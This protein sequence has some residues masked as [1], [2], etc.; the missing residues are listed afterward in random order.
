MNCEVSGTADGGM[1]LLARA[2]LNKQQQLGL[3]KCGL[4]P[5]THFERVANFSLVLWCC[6]VVVV[7]SY[8][9]GSTFKCRQ[10]RAVNRRYWVGRDVSGFML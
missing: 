7:S 8:C 2:S 5:G 9:R 6:L 1:K 10:A 3:H 4:D